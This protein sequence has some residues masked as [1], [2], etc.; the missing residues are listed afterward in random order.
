M[1]VCVCIYIYIYVHSNVVQKVR[2]LNMKGEHCASSYIIRK[3]N[4]YIVLE[5]KIEFFFPKNVRLYSFFEVRV[6]NFWEDLV[7]IYIYIYK[8]RNIKY[9]HIY[10]CD[11]SHTHS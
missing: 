2:S 11:I 7:Y 3:G 5:K 10:V 8:L 6:R 1:C 4:S 9:T